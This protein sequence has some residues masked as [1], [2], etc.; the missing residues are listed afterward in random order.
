M[1]TGP[2][3]PGRADGATAWGTE[4]GWVVC[5]QVGAHELRAQGGTLATGEALFH[6]QGRQLGATWGLS[7]SASLS[8]ATLL[9][10][11]RESAP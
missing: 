3:T 4:A 11:L 6:L 5:A 9:T 1:T 8:L 7:L 10:R 2:T